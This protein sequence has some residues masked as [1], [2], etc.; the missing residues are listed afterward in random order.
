MLGA[1]YIGLS[2]MDAYQKGL[3]TISNNV[4]NL[5]TS[6][7]KSSD[8]N[9]VDLFS[10]GGSGTSLSSNPNE[11]GGSGVAFGKPHIDM[12]QGELRSTDNDLDL[13]IQGNGFLMLLDGDKTYYT[14]TGQFMVGTDGFITEQGTD[15]RL[16]VLDESGRAT[17]LQIDTKRLNPPK[18]TTTIAITGNLVRGTDPSISNITVYDDN[19]GSHVWT[20]KLTRDTTTGT[21]DT[22]NV[23]IKDEHGVDVP[24]QSGLTTQIKLTGGIIDPTTAKPVFVSH[25]A[26]ASDIQ[27]TLD[28]SSGITIFAGTESNLSAKPDGNA[29][30]TLTA[31]SPIT[32]DDEGRVKLNYTNG[33]SETLGAIVIADF[34]DPQSLERIGN[35]LF[36]GTGG[37][38][39][40][41]VASGVDGAG[42]VQSKKTEASN[43]DLSQEFGQLIL[44]QRGFQASSQVVSVSNDMIQQLFGIRGQG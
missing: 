22:W 36:R 31:T 9:F 33:Q 4:A 38:A 24:S 43:V 39:P 42:T 34:R 37:N 17:A 32:I 29:V 23:T 35:G 5:N 15:Y 44:I 16:A 25:Q 3:Q 12:T 2:G 20:V 21:V 41:L 40:H 10:Y 30:G 11:N 13:A 14:R 18:A 6:G 26:N 1:I 19:G 8:V 7:F 27:V 28:F